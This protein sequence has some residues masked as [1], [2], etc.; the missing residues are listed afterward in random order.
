MARLKLLNPVLWGFSIALS[1][2]WGLG[3]FFSLQMA[4]QFG[5]PGLV[6]FAVP[7]ALGLIGFGLLTRHI[8]RKHNGDSFERHF[9][10]TVGKLRWVFLLYQVLAIALTFFAIFKYVFVPLG[11][12]LAVMALLLLGAGVLL[13][14]QF[15]IRTIKWSHLGMAAVIALSMLLIGWGGAL[16]FN[17]TAKDM[18]SLSVHGHESAVSWRFMGFFIPIV[19]GFLLGP[20]LDIQQWQRAIQIHREGS[21]VAVSY[22]FGAG[23]F[24]FI[25]MFHGTLGVTIWSEAQ[26]QGI[27]DQL[28]TTTMGIFHAKSAVVEF[29]F[30]IEG[31]GAPLLFQIMY[32]VFLC[33]CIIATV[34]SGYVALKWFQA[35]ATKKSDSV[36]M[37]LIPQDLL[38]SPL[39]PFVLAALVGLAG[40]YMDFELEYFMAFYGSFLVGYALVFL[41]RTT[42]AP[43]FAAF[44]QTTLVSLAAL[45]LG[46]FGLGY[47]EE[48]W[49]LMAAGALTPL[50]HAIVCIATR[51][52]VEEIK[53]SG[54]ID[55]IAEGEIGKAVQERLHP[56][57]DGQAKAPAE[58]PAPG[59]VAVVGHA[60]LS[61]A[62]SAAA[63][64]GASSWID[65]KWFVHSLTATYQDTNSVGNVYFAQYAMWVGKTRELFFNH[66]LPTFDLKTTSWF[67]LTRA[68]EHKFLKE[69]REFEQVEVRI[70]IASINRKFVTMEH[71]VHDSA[72]ELLGKG[73]QVLLFVSSEDYRI[74]DIPGECHRAFLP[75]L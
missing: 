27:S 56:S 57:G 19:V 68:F 20:W 51:K 53:R 67:I 7:N 34:D 73:K 30:N 59:P 58:A 66:A 45:S 36:L 18:A 26:R 24:F 33:L 42:F 32:V 15:N 44:T 63:G 55:R 35:D 70:R 74:L 37:S 8:A 40:V 17:Q 11:I 5:V 12:P 60:D 10:F 65:G 25:L 31:V 75:Y 64:G 71:Q 2:T 21:H 1:W 49:Y 38:T 48:V 41:F 13:G 22:L 4:I 50:V 69:T 47:F 16:Y 14:E 43:R 3:L 39:P 9:L 29:L 46:I 6:A 72:K 54:V 62:V 61:P 28:Y 52:A 23:I